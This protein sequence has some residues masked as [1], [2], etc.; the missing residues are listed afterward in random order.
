MYAAAKRNG[1]SMLR[2]VKDQPRQE[3]EPRGGRKELCATYEQL[4][5]ERSSWD[6]H[7]REIGMYLLPRVPRFF[8][9]DRNKGNKRHQ[10][11]YNDAATR[12]LRVMGAGMMAGASS[13]ARPWFEVT[14][15]DPELAKSHS[16]QLWLEDTSDRIRNIFR[17]SNTYRTLHSN[18]EN[19]G[20]FGTACGLVLPDSETVIHHYPSPIGEFCIAQDY[21][22]KVCTVFRL[23]QMTVR[24]IVEQFGMANCSTEVQEMH[25]KGSLEAGVKV[26]HA[27][28]RR[29]DRDPNRLDSRNMPWRSV[30]FEHGGGK[31]YDTVLRESGFRRFP[32][33]VPRWLIDGNDVYGGCPGMDA[34]GAVKGLQ[35]REI[36]L[37]RGIEYGIQSPVTAPTMLKG[38]G[39]NM[40]PGGI[41]YVDSPGQNQAIRPI[42]DIRAEMLQILR[43]D[44]NAVEARINEAFFKDLFL[45]VSNASDT[46]QR[47]AAEIAERREEKMVMV[48]PAYGRMQDEQLAPLVELTFWEAFENGMLAPLPADLEGQELQIEFVSVFAQALKM[49]GLAGQD[50]FMVTLGAVAQFKPEV[51]DRFNADGWV[52]SVSGVL[53]SPQ[54]IVPIEQAK[55]LRE[56]RN[57][58][59]A[60][61]E[62]AAMLAQQAKTARDLAAAPTGPGQQNA[63]TDVTQGLTGY[64]TPTSGAV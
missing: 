57:R 61:N 11:L 9:S 36:S 21:Q 34:L 37:A 48:G 51:L 59:D 16:V 10:V 14:T 58:R 20:G 29:R 64:T 23:Y 47:T 13:Q 12:A 35:L 53:V 32:A 3:Q 8:A 4:L 28:E 39:I 1:E 30:W 50:R 46:T 17:R 56:A 60:A 15:A 41:T 24:E 6:S 22:G 42:Y 25:R 63:L 7:W 49:V 31:E 44:S 19:V 5:N 52:D 55:Q 27:I 26:L 45:M 33:L 18:Y 54:L 43:N 38:K 2:L 62:Q 40:L